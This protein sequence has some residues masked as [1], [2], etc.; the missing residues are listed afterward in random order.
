[1][2]LPSQLHHPECPQSLPL[3]EGLACTC[4]GSLPGYV[5]RARAAS[6]ELTAQALATC[7]HP[8]NSRLTVTRL[9]YGSPLLICK[10]CGAATRN[11]GDTWELPRLVEKLAEVVKAPTSTSTK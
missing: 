1:M 8:S 2:N 11:Y 3:S 7:E 5:A 9:D 6:L 4:D 10:L